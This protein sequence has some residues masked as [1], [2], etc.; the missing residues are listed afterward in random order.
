MK[1]IVLPLSCL[2]LSAACAQELNTHVVLVRKLDAM[3]MP[4]E[5]FTARVAIRKTKAGD[6]A[7]KESN[8]R[9]FSRRRADTDGQAVLD[10]LLV[11]SAPEGDAGKMILFLADACWF[12]D[13]HAKRATRVPAQQVAAQALVADLMNWRF[14]DDFDHKLAGQEPV[15]IA[16]E[17]HACTV[18]DF[19][20]KPGVK[21]RSP[22]VRCW[23]DA[24][25]R[26]WKTEYYTASK[27]VFRS[28]L[29]TKYSI[30][31]GAERAVA[32]RIE[33]QGGIAEVSLSGVKGGRSPDAFFDP[34]QLP[35]LTGFRP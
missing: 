11:C 8:Y 18:L 20:P 2:M 21:N 32:L 17:A 9:Q 25:G 5:D 12:F 16:G 24:A 4:S 33:D 31:L 10:S 35:R 19:T 7:A 14:V 3:R 6:S 1:L 27:K 23:I 30:V 34:D 13:P 22:L 29:F 15:I 26:S 28:V